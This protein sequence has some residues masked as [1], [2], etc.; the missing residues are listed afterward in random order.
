MSTTHSVTRKPLPAHTAEPLTPEYKTP[1]YVE[2]QKSRFRN[3]AI[4]G[5]ATGWAMSDR[6][7]RVFPPHKRYFG[8]SRRILLIAIGVILLLI[9]ALIVGLAVG[10]R[11]KSKY[12]YLDL[13]PSNLSNKSQ[14]PRSPSTRWCKNVLG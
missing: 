4:A 10:L 12:T 2:P 11:N 3:R 13:T 9:L 7:D 8:H 1:E 14:G 6:F 5:S